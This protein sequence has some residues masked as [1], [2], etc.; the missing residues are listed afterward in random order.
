MLRR[1]DEIRSVAGQGTVKKI[2]AFTWK[3]GRLPEKKSQKDLVDAEFAPDPS[4]IVTSL[5][6]HI[7]KL[8]F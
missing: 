5:D 7:R 6:G 3:A 4:S 1:G 8:D 2:S